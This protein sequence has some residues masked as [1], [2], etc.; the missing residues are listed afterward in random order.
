MGGSC[1]VPAAFSGHIANYGFPQLPILGARSVYDENTKR[2]STPK[3]H[4]GIAI[5][6]IRVA[7]GSGRGNDNEWNI[8][9]KADA[10]LGAQMRFSARF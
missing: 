2:D 5:L 10:N 3:W 6:R 4:Q 1:L 8:C 7:S 9:R